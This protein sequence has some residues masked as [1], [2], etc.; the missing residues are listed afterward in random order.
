MCASGAGQP[1]PQFTAS[2]ASPFAPGCDGAVATGTVYENSEVEP[3]LAINPVDPGNLIGVWQQ[4]RWS[5]GGA[6]GLLTGHS[7]DGGR[8]WARTAAK[9]SRCTGGNAANGGDYERATDPWV[10]FGPD[11]TA[12]QVSVSF[13]GQEGQPGSSSAVLASRSQDGGR[14][15]SDPATLIRDGPAA[16][17]DKEAITADPTDARYA[18][19]TWDRLANNGG[20]S[21]LARTTDGGASWEPARAIFDPGTGNQTLNNQIVVLPNGTLVNFMTLFNP[22]PKLAVIRSTDKGLSWSPPVV[23]ALA[24]ALGVE[25]GGY[26]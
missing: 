18:Y 26:G 9:F 3:M 2:A 21:Y 11:G 13:I 25:D 1:D 24:Q 16:F 10:S 14:T 15:W 4:D 6:R 20:P 17:N 19:A 5:N 12:Y 7:H 22:D 23:I 8:T